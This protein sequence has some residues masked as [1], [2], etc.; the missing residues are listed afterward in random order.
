MRCRLVVACAIA[1]AIARVPLFAM[2]Y[3]G[4]VL[5]GDVPVPGATVIASRG[6]R[7]VFTLTDEQ[8]AFTFTEL[9]EGAW[10]VRVEG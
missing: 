2:G 6:D 1:L 8:G 3:S 10:T 5:F 7:Q 9:D 4:R